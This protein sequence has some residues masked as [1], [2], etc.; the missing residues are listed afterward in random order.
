[1]HGFYGEKITSMLVNNSIHLTEYQIHGNHI[2]PF[3]YILVS[4]LIPYIYIIRLFYL[5]LS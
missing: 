3:A 1:M 5:I 2:I 4:R